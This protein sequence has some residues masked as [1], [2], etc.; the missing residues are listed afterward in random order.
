[1]GKKEEFVANLE[2]TCPD[3]GNIVEETKHIALISQVAGVAFLIL[4]VGLIMITGLINSG[5]IGL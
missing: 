2:A 3:L 1:M 5:G 4:L